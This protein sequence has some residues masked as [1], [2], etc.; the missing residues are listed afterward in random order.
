MKDINEEL[1]KELD[2]NIGDLLPA[3]NFEKQKPE[4]KD[5]I[6]KEYNAL[7]EK[8]QE[9]LN[10][11]AQPVKENLTATETAI[12]RRKKLIADQQEAENEED[13]EPKARKR[14]QKLMDKRAIA[15]ERD[16]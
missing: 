6:S 15:M 8:M 11:R 16:V 1:I 3:L 12:E 13:E 9:G 4:S 2:D 10:K 5:K 7:I 14:D